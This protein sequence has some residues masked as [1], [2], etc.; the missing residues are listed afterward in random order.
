MAKDTQLSATTTLAAVR[1][2]TP[3][4]TRPQTVTVAPSSGRHGTWFGLG[5]GSGFG[6]G[7]GVRLGLGLESGLGLGPG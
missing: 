4:P 1:G 2:R 7:L 5:L 6:L 3:Q